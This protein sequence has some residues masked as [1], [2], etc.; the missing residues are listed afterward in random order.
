MSCID[1]RVFGNFEHI[2][3]IDDVFYKPK[4]YSEK[5]YKIMYVIFHEPQNDM[6]TCW[7]LV[8]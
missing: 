4:W 8:L 6:V 1:I 7:K 3:L 5:E 2:Q